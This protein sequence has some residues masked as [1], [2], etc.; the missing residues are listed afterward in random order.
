MQNRRIFKVSVFVLVNLQG[1][2]V[3]CAITAKCTK[4]TEFS[5]SHSLASRICPN[6]GDA[7]FGITQ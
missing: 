1:V 6:L 4:F 2:M 3:I 7:T 5:I